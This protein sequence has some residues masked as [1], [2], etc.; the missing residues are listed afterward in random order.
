MKT[1]KRTNSYKTKILNKEPRS[2]SF[3]LGLTFPVSRIRRHLRQ[4]VDVPKLSMTAAVYITTVLEYMCAEIL[5]VA[6]NKARE[7]G[8]KRIMP[9]HLL[10]G[11][12]HDL[13]LKEFYEN[14]IIPE[15]E[16]ISKLKLD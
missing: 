8:F 4:K 14:A 3:K 6:G 9:R 10:Q 11:I 15:T 7:K 16:F 1:I 12:K 2:I 5:E 13:E